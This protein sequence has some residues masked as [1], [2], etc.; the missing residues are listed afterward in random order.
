MSTQNRKKKSR[1]GNRGSKTLIPQHVRA[2]QNTWTR[3][4]MPSELDVK[5]VYTLGYVA[6]ATL[7]TDIVYFNPN[8]YIP[9]VSGT[10]AAAEFVNYAAIYDF[11]RVVKF[12]IKMEAINQDTTPVQV[13]FLCHNENFFSEGFDNLMGNQWATGRTLGSVNGGASRTAW[14]KTLNMETL[15]GSRAPDTADSYRAVINAAPSDVVWAGM[16]IFSTGTMTNGVT[17]TAQITQWI[18]FYNPDLTS[19]TT[20]PSVTSK[21]QLDAI[22]ARRDARKRASEI[23]YKSKEKQ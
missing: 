18:R 17:G 19:Q 9:E 14:K 20:A 2:P 7:T 12:S 10:K 23:G 21:Q 11:Y 4:G 5:L 8:S 1:N 13:V 16:K 3:P 6:G 22:Q 15:T